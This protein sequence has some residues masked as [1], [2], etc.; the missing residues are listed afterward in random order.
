[1]ERYSNARYDLIP[2]GN[3]KLK[4]VSV[5]YT[6]KGRLHHYFIF[7][8]KKN[9]LSDKDYIKEAKKQFNEDYKSGR[10]NKLARPDR[11]KPLLITLTAI[12]GAAAIALGGFLGY[13]YLTGGFNGGGS[14]GGGGD[15]PTGDWVE[16][17]EGDVLDPNGILENITT[18]QTIER[19]VAIFDSHPTGNIVYTHD[20]LKMLNS[21]TP[22]VEFYRFNLN[23]VPFYEAKGISQDTD[24]YFY[25]IYDNGENALEKGLHVWFSEKDYVTAE[26]QP[27]DV[28]YC[29]KIPD[30]GSRE[31]AVGAIKSLMIYGDGDK[32]TPL[33]D[34]MFGTDPDGGI[35][36]LTDGEAMTTYTM[37]KQFAEQHPDEATF[38]CKFSKL[39]ND[40]LS[41]KYDHSFD[42]SGYNLS[43]TRSFE[44]QSGIVIN[45]SSTVIGGTISNGGT[46]TTKTDFNE[47]TVPDYSDWPTE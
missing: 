18:Y 2:S 43:D 42:S 37:E 39:P 35:N 17:T 5:T 7:L 47:V 15:D 23:D 14:G 45:Y 10:V 19:F 11:S 13:M 3:D 40:N 22:D 4:E 16:V 38:N 28:S 6:V 8:Q 21:N 25:Y 20:E 33:K 32:I 12:F 46:T 9:N 34:Y 44:M 29:L 41:L 31:N 27:S 24:G 26:L 36:F 30:T 1:M